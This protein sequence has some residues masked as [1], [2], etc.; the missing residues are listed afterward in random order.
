MQNITIKMN[1]GP[2]LFCQLKTFFNCKHYTITNCKKSCALFIN[3]CY[4]YYPLFDLRLTSSL[5]ETIASPCSLTALH[6]YTPPSKLLGLRI[7]REQMPWLFNCLNL[8][9]SPMIIW[10]FIHWILGCRE[11]KKKGDEKESK[12]FCSYSV[13]SWNARMY[14]YLSKACW[15]MN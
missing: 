9:S 4:M 11:R 7:S 5:Q 13:I 8:G 12:C 14:H 3:T 1:A 2:Y 15:W 10:F 6:M